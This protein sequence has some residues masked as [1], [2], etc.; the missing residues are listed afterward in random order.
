MKLRL[1]TGA[2]KKKLCLEL[3]ADKWIDFQESKNI[4]EEIQA[5]TDGLGAHSALVTTASVSMCRS[6]G[7]YSWNSIEFGI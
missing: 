4:V 7:F 6:K 5:I 1:D 3:G 2:D